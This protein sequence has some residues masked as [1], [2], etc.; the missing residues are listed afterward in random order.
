MSATV[1]CS[2]P[3][4]T[5]V[6]VIA[7]LDDPLLQDS[8][9]EP[10]TVMRDEQRGHRR[11]VHSDAD[12]VA[13]D[14]WLGHLEQCPTDAVAV[15][16]ADLAVG[17]ALD[18][19]VLAELA[20]PEVVPSELALPIAVGVDLVDEHRAMLAAMGNPVGLVVAVDVDA[21]DHSRVGHR[22]LPDR[23]LDGLALPLHL[24]WAADVDRH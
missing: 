20:V 18:G 21:P 10:G 17:E 5:F 9:V 14:P 11:V 8:E 23:R 4:A 15:A 7:G 3:S 16:D 22:V 13:G 19:E 6:D 12:A 24:A 1:S 2:G